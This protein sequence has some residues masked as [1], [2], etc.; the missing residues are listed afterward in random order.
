MTNLIVREP[1]LNP[2]LQV[3]GYEL[4]MQKSGNRLAEDAE[5]ESLLRHAGENFVSPDGSWLLGTN[6]LF[7]KVTPSH[8]SSTSQTLH[9]L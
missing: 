9:Q 7:L 6:L 4:T 1:L 8:L 5:L 2:S 3:I